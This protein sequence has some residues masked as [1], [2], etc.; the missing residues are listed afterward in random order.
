MKNICL[1]YIKHVR[2]IGALMTIIPVL[3]AYGY[4][5]M[6]M[7]YREVYLLRLALSIIFGG[8]AG[9]YANRFAVNNWQARVR[10]KNIGESIRIG[11]AGGLFAGIGNAALPPLF[12]LISSNHIEMA[13]DMIIGVTAFGAVSGLLLGGSLGLIGATYLFTG[14]GQKI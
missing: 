11:A 2:L 14:D 1:G 4:T 8:L 7:P 6:T 3:L 12:T 5:F 9:A 13:K 10:S